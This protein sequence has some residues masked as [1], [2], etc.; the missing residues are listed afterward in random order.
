MKEKAGEAKI[1]KA[2][3]TSLLAEETVNS[4]NNAKKKLSG[5]GV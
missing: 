5:I 2:R 1:V 3:M 4:D